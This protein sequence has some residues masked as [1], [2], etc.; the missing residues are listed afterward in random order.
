LLILLLMP[1]NAIICI[2]AEKGG[3][4][5]VSNRQRYACS[6]PGKDHAYSWA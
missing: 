6:F 3:N 2:C 1:R 5:D 4:I